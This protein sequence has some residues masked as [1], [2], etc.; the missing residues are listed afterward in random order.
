MQETS[1][2]PGVE[3]G[4]DV[5][6]HGPCVCDLVNSECPKRCRQDCKTKAE[7]IDIPPDLVEYHGPLPRAETTQGNAPQH[8]G[9][10][11]CALSDSTP[12]ASATLLLVVLLLAARRWLRPH[13]PHR[14]TPGSHP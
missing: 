6:Y 9:C 3:V 2:S 10:A 14:A 8:G 12:S 13:G 4:G 11:G 5:G 7:C 1:S